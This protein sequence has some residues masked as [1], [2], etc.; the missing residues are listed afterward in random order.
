MLN[1]LILFG[2]CAVLASTALIASCSDDPSGST[3]TTDVGGTPSTGGMGGS[4]AAGGSTGGNGGSGGTP[5][6][7]NWDCL[8]MVAAPMY[9]NGPSHV[10]NYTMNDLVTDAPLVGVT[11]KVCDVA[12]P[13]CANSNDE[14]VTDMMGLIQLATPT[15]EAQYLEISGANIPMHLAIAF[16]PPDTDPFDITVKPVTT[17]TLNVFAALLTTTIDSARG[18]LGATVDD[19]DGTRASGVSFSV[20]TADGMSVFGYLDAAGSPDSAL[21]ETSVGGAVGVFNLPAGTATIT[22]TIVASGTTLPDRTVLIRADS[23]TYAG[24]SP[25]PDAQ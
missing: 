3:S 19:C 17:A 15:S 13:T 7:A 12:D 4:G 1:R 5:P 18:I 14:G 20:D 23:V 24:S 2:T 16:A 21:T 6:P 8:G 25:I 9:E 11:V 22:A 10:G